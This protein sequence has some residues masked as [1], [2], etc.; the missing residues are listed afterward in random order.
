MRNLIIAGAMALSVLMPSAA[1][2]APVKNVGVCHLSQGS[3]RYEFITVNPH[4]LKHGHT[5]AKGDIL[6]VNG[7]PVTREVCLGLN[8]PLVTKE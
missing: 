8:Q 4:S 1:M 3:G 5:E 6:M 2:A 7:S